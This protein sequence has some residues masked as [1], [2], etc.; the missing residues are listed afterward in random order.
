[1]SIQL[2]VIS[3]ERGGESIESVFR[4]VR[5]F[6]PISLVLFHV[7]HFVL[8]AHLCPSCSAFCHSAPRTALSGSAGRLFR[9]SAL[10]SR[11]LPR[12]HPPYCNASL[13]MFVVLLFVTVL[14]FC[15]NR[16]SKTVWIGFRRNGCL[17][18]FGVVALM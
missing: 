17:P 13:K 2:R 4:R 9:Y 16:Q 5:C 18:T 14:L 10:R 15:F 1:M 6:G 8:H 12:A 11:P 7:V 3:F